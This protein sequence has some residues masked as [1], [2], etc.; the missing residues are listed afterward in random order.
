MIVCLLAKYIFNNLLKKRERGPED[1]N[2]PERIRN[3]RNEEIL[4]GS[5]AN[6]K[7]L[8][9]TIDNAIKHQSDPFR[10]VINL[11]KFGFTVNEYKILGYNLNFVPTPGSINKNELLHDVQKFNRRI[12]LRSHFGTTLQKGDLYFKSNSTWE[13]NDVY[14]TVKTFIEDF[15]QKV[16]QPKKR[17]KRRK[18]EPQEP[19]QE[20]KPSL[21]GPKE[22]R[23][24]SNLQ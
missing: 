10:Q 8:R 9:Q 2:G 14:H 11:S 7:R 17:L 23:R 5:Y 4:N 13:P 15:N 21:G 18:D 24:H 6:H 1:G 19:E 22:K 3:K 20:R 16:R 12:K